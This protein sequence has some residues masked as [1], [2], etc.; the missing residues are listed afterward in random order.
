[1]KTL[2]VYDTQY[3]NTEEIAHAIV[4]ALR[5]FG[6]AR[7]VH[8]QH[9][10]TVSLQEVDLLILGCPTHGFR[11]T[12]AM[13]S[14]FGSI[15]TFGALPTHRTV[16]LAVACFDTRFRGFLWK[17]SAATHLD[18]QFRTI[19]IE[20]LVPAESFFVKSMKK[21]GPLLTGEIKRATNWARSM[22]Q[23]FE[24]QAGHLVVH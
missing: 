5:P 3:G 19:G 2:V 17:N 12:P 16:Q 7:A 24:M 1:M 23:W 22:H 6:E 20:P 15:S 9:A 4:N 21:E 13:Q 18:K 11:P 14:F 10:H 8:V